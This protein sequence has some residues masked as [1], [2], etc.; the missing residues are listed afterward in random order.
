MKRPPLTRL[1]ILRKRATCGRSEKGI[2]G[3]VRCRWRQGEIYKKGMVTGE[4]TY[5]SRNGEEEH[6]K[7][8]I[9]EQAGG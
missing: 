5:W 4:T 9:K 8:T 2:H 7:D 1:A 6:Q 3:V